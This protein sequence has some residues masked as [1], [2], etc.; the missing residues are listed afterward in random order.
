MKAAAYSC[1]P[2]TTLP[3]RRRGSHFDS[4]NAL[5]GSRILWDAEPVT[6]T[7]GE[8]LNPKGAMVQFILGADAVT[9]ITASWSSRRL[10]SFFRESVRGSPRWHGTAQHRMCFRLSVRPDTL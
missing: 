1:T 5:L 8:A 4:S 7:A 6:I 2:R 3:G 10:C 9:S